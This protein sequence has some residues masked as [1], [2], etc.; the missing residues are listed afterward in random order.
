MNNR[1]SDIGIFGSLLLLERCLS[2]HASDIER[3]R[4]EH[5]LNMDVKLILRRRRLFDVSFDLGEPGE[6]FQQSQLT[7][8]IHLQSLG[9]HCRFHFHG[10]DRV[11]LEGLDDLVGRTTPH[12]VF[13]LV[14]NGIENARA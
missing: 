7:R 5:T 8:A 9:G 12:G 3:Q 4:S 13:E 11:F 6:L 2:W 14:L 1:E 10:L